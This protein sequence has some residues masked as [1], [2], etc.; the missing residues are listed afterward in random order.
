MPDIE[1]RL[2][3]LGDDAPNEATISF[4]MVAEGESIGKDDD[5]VEVLTDKAT[6]N[7]PSPMSG[8]VKR[9]CA[10]EDDVVKVGDILAVIETEEE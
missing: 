7:V 9:I 3:E 5:L 10:K 4:F 8:K 1:V 6:F 2:P